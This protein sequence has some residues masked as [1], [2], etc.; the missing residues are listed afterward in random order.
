MSQVVADRLLHIFAHQ[1][2]VN[3]DTEPELMF[4]ISDC[5]ENLPEGWEI[6]I[7]KGEHEG[8]RLNYLS[9]L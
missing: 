2:G 8:T 6:V 3:P 9:I 4:I 1:Y 5:L 7:G